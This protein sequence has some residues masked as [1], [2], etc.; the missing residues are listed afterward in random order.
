MKSGK[1]NKTLKLL[2][3]T[4]VTLFSLVTVFAA[5]IAWFALNDNTNGNGLT[6]TVT[7]DEDSV[8]TVAI[9][10]C[11]LNQS[12]T[13]N[14]VFDS[15]ATTDT[16]VL[17]DYSELN[18]SQPTLLLFEL[19]GDEASTADKI[20]ITATSTSD[21]YVTEIT[22]DNYN[23]F[24]FS[25]A[26]CF[27]TIAVTSATFPFNSVTAG[28]LSEEIS[29]VTIEDDAFTGFNKTITIFDGSTMANPPAQP[30]TYLGVVLDYYDDAL[31][32]ISSCNTGNEFRLGFVFD[33]SMSVE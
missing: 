17:P 20:K 14:L 5:T 11:I 32:Y 29:F 30:L 2:G 19:S 7:Q 12:T 15:Q 24:P 22:E 23:S 33:F 18:K 1:N 3:A 9:H 21:N 26:I 4:A 6:I 27:K 16:L 10:R 13:T 8:E 25:S 28:N 31:Q